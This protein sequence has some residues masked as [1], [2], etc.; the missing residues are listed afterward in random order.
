MNYF[1]GG[2]LSYV[3]YN[4]TLGEK[5]L[6]GIVCWY[7]T[8]IKCSRDMMVVFTMFVGVLGV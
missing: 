8:G 3:V 4:T 1:A 7:N 5:A 6:P 2:E